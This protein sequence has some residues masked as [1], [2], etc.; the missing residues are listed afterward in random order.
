MPYIIKNLTANVVVLSETLSIPANSDVVIDAVTAN[1]KQVELSGLIKVGYIN[2][3][4]AALRI[5]AKE[6]E[7]KTLKKSK[8]KKTED[9][10]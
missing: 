10:K 1:I 6:L 7:K 2:D 8:S 9:A 4:M 3:E 5:K